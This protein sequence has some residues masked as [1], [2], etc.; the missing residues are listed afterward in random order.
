[1]ALVINTFRMLNPIPDANVDASGVVKQTGV[2]VYCNAT[3]GAATG[4]ALNC[5]LFGI[6]T[7]YGIIANP[8][9]GGNAGTTAAIT[10]VQATGVITWPGVNGTYDCILIGE[11]AQ[12]VATVGTSGAGTLNG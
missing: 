9:N 8:G 3:V 10:Y 2:M 7:L 6:S 5:R 12:S 4:G 11:A 1:M